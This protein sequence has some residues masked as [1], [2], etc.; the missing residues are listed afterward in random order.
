MRAVLSLGSNLGDSESILSSAAEALN[1]VG[2]VIALSNFF[3]NRPV[4]GPPQPDYLNAVLIIETQL[5]P[6]ELLTVCQAIER[7]FG[8]TRDSDEVRWGPRTLDI[9][10][11][12]CD[13][14]IRESEILTLPHPRMH[15][16]AFVLL[17]LAEIDPD[18]LLTTGQT[19]VECLSEMGLR[20]PSQWATQ[21]I[22]K[23]DESR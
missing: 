14:L 3:L 11:I 17:P 4:G 12:T 1:E 15:E 7:V 21:G 8:R 16:R 23:R 19:V 13:Q 20:T 2:E 10:L 9:D 18:Y 22:T 6:E 5:E